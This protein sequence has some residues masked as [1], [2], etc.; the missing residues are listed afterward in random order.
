MDHQTMQTIITGLACA[1][2]VVAPMAGFFLR[3]DRR[4]TRV[5][6][7]V[8]TALERCATRPGP[9]VPLSAVTLRQVVRP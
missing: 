4:L 2:G 8:E 6:T 9:G 7:L 1:A 5:E 3:L